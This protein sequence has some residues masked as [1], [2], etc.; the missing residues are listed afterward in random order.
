MQT[1]TWHIEKGSRLIPEARSFELIVGFYMWAPLKKLETFSP[2]FFLRVAM[3]T[4]SCKQ[5]LVRAGWGGMFEKKGG[6]HSSAS[7]FLDL[8]KRFLFN[9]DESKEWLVSDLETSH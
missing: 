7:F 9:L 4:L 1:V 6:T 5:C 8:E 2:G 3:V